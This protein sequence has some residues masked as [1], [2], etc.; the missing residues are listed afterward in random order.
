MVNSKQLF[1]FLILILVTL[2]LRDLPYVN[3]VFISRLWL[4]YFAILMFVILASLKFRVTILWYT[5]IALFVMSFMLT[6]MRLPFFAESV[7]VLIYFFLW[8][9]V[10]HRLIEFAK[11]RR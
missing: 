7:G 4:V 10:I 9:I 11:D 1:V 5:T 3:V 6:L 2:L 8:I